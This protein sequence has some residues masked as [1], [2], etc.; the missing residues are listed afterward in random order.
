MTE[1]L[2][3]KSEYKNISYTGNWINIA[4]GEI[5]E[6]FFF[7]VYTDLFSITRPIVFLEWANF[8]RTKTQ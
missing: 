8:L 3:F 1:K 2:R 4:G 7:P 6:Q 5:Y